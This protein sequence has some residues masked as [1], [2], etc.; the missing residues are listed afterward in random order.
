LPFHGWH[1]ILDAPRYSELSRCAGTSETPTAYFPAYRAS[2][3]HDA[4]LT[5]GA[6]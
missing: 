5:G 2:A 4:L 3:N 6:R 1:V